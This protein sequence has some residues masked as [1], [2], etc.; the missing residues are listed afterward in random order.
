MTTIDNASLVAWRRQF[1]CYPET[2]W[3]EFYTTAILIKTLEEIGHHVLE[4]EQIINPDFIRGRNPSIVEKA[5]RAAKERGVDDALLERIGDYTGCAAIFD[6]GR[7]G[8]T[9]AFRFDIDCV[10]VQETDTA[11]HIPNQEG[12][13]STNQGYM[14]ACGHDGHMAIGLGVAKWLIENKDRPLKGVI[15]LIFQPAEEGVRGAKPIAESGILDDVDYFAC[16][17]LGCDIPSGVVVAA[18]ERYLS[19]LKMESPFSTN[20]K[21]PTVIV[22]AMRPATA[23]SADGPMNLLEGVVLAADKKAEDRGVMVVLN[24][25]IGSAFYTT[26]ANSTT[27]DAFKSYE[28]GYLGVFVSGN[29]KFY[30]TPAQPIDRA[31]FDVSKIDDLPSVEIIY[32]YQDQTPALLDAA[33]SNGAK[34]IIVA[35]SGNGN[36]SSNM[37][38]AIKQLSD[39]GVPIVMATRTGSGYVSS[40]SFAIGAGFLNPQKSRILLQ[41]ALAS[42]ADIKQISNYFDSQR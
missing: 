22:G 1:H 41:L 8:P 37:E 18:P 34:G 29:P 9:V 38:E 24:D 14:H 15:K 40:K 25:R 42:G 36:V 28:P 30:Y 19:T 6:T 3:G 17:H 26:K 32:A 5:K 23:I 4:G 33:I 16:G 7:P 35:G 11:E 13:S 12:F 21:K 2:G 20:N 31:F 10:N 27:P 39:K